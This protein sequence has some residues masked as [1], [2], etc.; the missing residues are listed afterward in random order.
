MFKKLL[1]LILLTLLISTIHAQTVAYVATTNSTQITVIDT[2]SNTV[3]ATIDIG[4]LPIGVVFSPDGAR[5]YA[6]SESSISVIDTA[7]NSVIGQIPNA[8]PGGFGFGYPAITPD[9]KTLYAPSFSQSVLVIST[10]TNSV[11]A[12]VP[13]SFASAVVITPDGTRAYVFDAFGTVSVVDTATNTVIQSIAVNSFLGTG[14]QP[15]IAITPDGR[16]V[17]VSGAERTNVDV[18]ATTSNTDFTSIALPFFSPFVPDFPAIAITPDGSRVYVTDND[19]GL[20][21]VIDTATNTLE[22]SSIPVSFPLALAATPDGAFVYAAG[23][24]T[25]S[26]ISTAT[27][28]VVATIPVGG[29]GI[30]IATLSSPFAAFTIDNL[31]IN[32]NL[33]E[34]GD[35][36]L[37]ANAAIDLVHQPLTLT[38]NNFSLTIP[39]GSFRQ[40]GGNMHFVFEGTVNGLGVNF[41]IKAVNGSSTQFTYTVNVHG[42]NITGPDPATV[43]LKIGR[44]RGSTTAE[45]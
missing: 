18:I 36:A 21:D 39:A 3:S 27:N 44:N 13:I 40:V 15:G 38:V 5:A 6:T 8:A 19:D 25:T 28:K 22:S 20:V 43:G 17:Y 1:L 29:L 37:G 35:F 16:D 42:V 41:D 7:S 24:S 14:A 31:V 33:H 2:P 12:T 11:T 30:A 26:V 34:Q 32:N 45:F 4:D 23:F 9:G 10:A